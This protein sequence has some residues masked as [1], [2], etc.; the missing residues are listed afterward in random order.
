M[1]VLSAVGSIF[2][3]FCPPEV[4]FFKCIVPSNRPHGKTHNN[5]HS[6]TNPPPKCSTPH[7]FSKIPRN[8]WTPMI[9]KWKPHNSWTCPTWT[10]KGVI[11]IW[12]WRCAKAFLNLP[13]KC[14]CIYFISFQFWAHDNGWTHFWKQLTSNLGWL[15]LDSELSH[16]LQ[17]TNYMC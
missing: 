13:W 16:V 6:H 7:R 1:Q 8:F 14:S 4:Q 12:K 5:F 3:I 2:Q 17:T 15:R 11:K 9:F 10:W